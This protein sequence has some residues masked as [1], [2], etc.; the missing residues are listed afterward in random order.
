MD[1]FEKRNKLVEL[2]GQYDDALQVVG[3]LGSIIGSEHNAVLGMV[4][5]PA[6]EGGARARIT[7]LNALFEVMLEPF[8]VTATPNEMPAVLI[9][10]VDAD[11]VAVVSARIV[12]RVFVVYEADPPLQFTDSAMLTGQLASWLFSGLIDRFVER[13]PRITPGAA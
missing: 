10:I 2:A 3:Q 7:V 9:R 5:Q 1:P 13:T 8:F 4:F 6:A 11:G 12:N